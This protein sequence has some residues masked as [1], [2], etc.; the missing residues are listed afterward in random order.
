MRYIG[1][2]KTKSILIAL[3]FVLVSLSSF[4]QKVKPEHEKIV[5]Q[6]MTSVTSHSEKGVLKSLDKSYKKEQ[7]AFLEG[8]KEQLVNEL[9]GG[10]NL[11]DTDVYLN[12]KISEITKI[13]VVQVIELKGDAGYTYI[14]KVWKGEQAIM[15]SLHLKANGKKFGFEGGRG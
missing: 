1:L 4:S 11:A 5:S 12:F 9:F 7:L 15:S 13:E 8:N 6:L 10:Q 2:M 3:S 14:F